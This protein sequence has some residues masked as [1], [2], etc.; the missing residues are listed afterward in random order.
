MQILEDLGRTTKQMCQ[1][2]IDIQYTKKDIVLFEI[3]C[4]ILAKYYGLNLSFGSGNNFWPI[5]VKISLL[6]LSHSPTQSHFMYN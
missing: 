2:P 6:E 4:A 1:V 3:Q 5:C